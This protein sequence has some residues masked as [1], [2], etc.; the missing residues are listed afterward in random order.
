MYVDV[1]VIV[2]KQTTSDFYHPYAASGYRNEHGLV[3]KGIT[4]YLM[5]SWEKPK[6]PDHA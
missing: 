6:G 4:T 3:E 5:D 2:S 1:D